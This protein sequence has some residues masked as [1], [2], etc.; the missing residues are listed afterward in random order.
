[1]SKSELQ[2]EGLDPAPAEVWA[3]GERSSDQIRSR[4]RVVDHGEVFTPP[5]LVD[6]MLGTV[7]EEADR[8]DSRFLEPACGSGNFLSEILRRKL[9][10]VERTYGRSDFERQHFALLAAM[11]VYGV[12]LLPDNIAECREG[13]LSQFISFMGSR[14]PVE[15]IRAASFVWSINLVHGDALTMKTS[16][17]EAITF[18]EWGYLGK[19]KYQRRDFRL[20][21]LTLA[22]T[23]SAEGS[24]FAELGK[25]DL[26]TPVASYPLMTVSDLAAAGSFSRDLQR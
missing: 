11:C 3:P 23:F 18:A 12:E 25:Q 15:F 26:F 24:L 10:A 22:S 9:V 7:E 20:R 8:I 19:G 6:A 4:Q 2:G 17:G 13:L 5:W 14:T 21:D 16:T 1:M